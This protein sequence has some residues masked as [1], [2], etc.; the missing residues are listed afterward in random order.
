MLVG[1]GFLIL[2]TVID[3]TQRVLLLRWEIHKNKRP[4]RI[5]DMQSQAVHAEQASQQSTHATWLTRVMK[6]RSWPSCLT[7]AAVHEGNAKT[8]DVL[9]CY[10]LRYSNFVKKLWQL[11]WRATLLISSHE[12][13]GGEP[14]SKEGRGTGTR[15]QGRQATKEKMEWGA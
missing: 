6:G 1:I 9:Q 14:G 7:M 8:N 12:F 11:W 15:T 3:L 10:A 13:G 4:R 2:W 5:V